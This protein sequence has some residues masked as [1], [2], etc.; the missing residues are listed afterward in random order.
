MYNNI[1]L[2]LYNMYI[3]NYK[4]GTTYPDHVQTEL[5]LFLLRTFLGPDPSLKDWSW[6]VAC[7]GIQSAT[8]AWVGTFHEDWWHDLQ[9]EVLRVWYGSRWPA[10][11]TCF[12]WL[13]LGYH[14]FFS[15]LL[16]RWLLRPNWVAFANVLWLP[17]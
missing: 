1:A 8:S 11:L 15:V 13:A 5:I 3:S 7:I 12:T 10:S 4:I 14:V 6:K 17:R 2:T 16:R 9:G